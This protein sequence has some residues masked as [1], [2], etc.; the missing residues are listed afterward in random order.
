MRQMNFLNKKRNMLTSKQLS[1]ALA[2]K[3]DRTFLK[4]GVQKNYTN[5]TQEPYTEYKY[6]KG[7]SSN[8]DN[9]NGENS[10]GGQM[11]LSEGL[12]WA[13]KIKGFFGNSGGASAGAGVGASAGAEAGAAASGS[14]AA[15]GASGGG[16]GTPWGAIA[17]VARTGYDTIMDKD[18]KDYSDLEQ[19]VIYPLQGAAIGGSYGGGWGALGGALYGLGYAFKDDIGLKDNDWL[20]TVL[21]PIGMG[22]EHQGLIQL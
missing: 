15:G 6:I 22:D 2:E 4:G 10:G 17:G 5:N 1:D 3:E 11:S 12:G 16:G 18:G 8:S 13:N 19:G 14:S 7:Y 20:T 21:F 9:G